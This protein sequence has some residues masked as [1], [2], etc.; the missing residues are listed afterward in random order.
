MIRRLFFFAV[1]GV[2]AFIVDVSVLYLLKGFLGPY[3]ARCFS[4]FFAVIVTWFFNRVITYHDRSSGMRKRNEFA[5]YFLLMLWGGGVNYGI[6]AFL[7]HEYSMVSSHPVLGVASGSL[8]GMFVNIITT[9]W[10][11]FRHINV[12]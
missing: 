2:I 1:S 7:I 3:L 6:Y 11:L 12:R 4:F 5:A 10:V 9:R 8:A